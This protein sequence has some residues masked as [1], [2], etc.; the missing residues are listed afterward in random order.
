MYSEPWAKLTTRVT[1]KITVS[2]AATRN[3]E[4]A[5]ASPVRSLDDDGIHAGAQAAGR[6]FRT[7]ASGGMTAAP[8]T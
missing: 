2:P 7:S 6:S 8:S 4:E 3:S 5:P 1:P